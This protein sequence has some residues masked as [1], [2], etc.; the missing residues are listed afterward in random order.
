VAVTS[1]LALALELKGLKE[2][3]SRLR[4]A[5]EVLERRVPNP[6]D[7]L[8]TAEVRSL[9]GISPTTLYA[10]SRRTPPV[11]TRMRRPG[12]RGTWWRRAEIE[13]YLRGLSE[14]IELDLSERRMP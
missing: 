9:Y 1:D 6:P 4:R 12:R 2:E 11:F 10:L 14:P 8:T 13:D 7:L 5:I 3:L